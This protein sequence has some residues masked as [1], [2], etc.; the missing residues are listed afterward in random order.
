MAFVG[1]AF[2]TWLGHEDRVLANGSSDLL[3]RIPE[4]SPAPSALW[5]HMETMA[6]GD[7]GSSS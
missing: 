2:G 6:G 4:T 1:G 7:P 3:K 5:G